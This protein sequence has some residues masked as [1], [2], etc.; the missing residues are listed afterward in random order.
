L[1]ISC[2]VHDHVLVVLPPALHM[3]A[4]GKVFDRPNLVSQQ[5]R[6]LVLLC[7]SM[8]LRRQ[9]RF[10]SFL[11]V[12]RWKTFFATASTWSRSAAETKGPK[13]VPSPVARRA[14]TSLGYS[15]FVSSIHA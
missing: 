12:R 7:R 10:G 14:I 8:C 11:Q 9:G 1:P 6:P 13:N 3:L 5:K 15:S 2:L 4:F